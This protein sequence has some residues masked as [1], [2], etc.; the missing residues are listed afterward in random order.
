MAR[1]RIVHMVE[2]FDMLGGPPKLVRLIVG[3]RLREDYEFHIVTYQISGID[4]LAISRLRRQLG[5]ISPDIVHIH[6]LKNDAFHAALAAKISLAKRILITVHG[7]TANSIHAYRTLRMRLR[8][9]IVSYFLEPITLHLAD[10]V[11]CVCDAMKRTSR[12]RKAAGARLRD[13]I[14]NGIAIA[15]EVIRNKQLR[16]EFGFS[17]DEV[18]VVYVGRLAK[19]KGLE[20]LAAA[21]RS[22]VM[23][24]DRSRTNAQPTN[25]VMITH[26]RVR[27]LLV[28]DGK[29]YHQIRR[30]FDPLINAKRVFLTG[31][32]NDIH[33][34]N[35]MA[36]IFVLPSYHENLS[37][38]LLEA[39]NAGLP[40]IATA[41]GGNPEVVV[42]GLTGRL[43]PPQDAD[44]LARCILQLSAD[45]DLRR[46]MG[47]AG[48]IRLS[49]HFSLDFMIR[50]TDQVYRS[51]LV[52]CG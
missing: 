31:T 38:A 27:L 26:P 28:G 18:V 6:G 24:E 5:H 35:A 1:P 20:V 2:T 39:M 36:D 17:D 14:H 45:P 21:M 9:F 13:T 33:A 41:V 12:L 46:Q 49:A 48:R 47:Q 22:I 11:Y 32:R 3:S 51:L 44:A 23:Q 50:K 25:G 30:E 52:Q 10:A 8:R 29:D 40:V 15:P 16:E 7:S 19:D 4:L 42:D 43:V 37:F 34:V